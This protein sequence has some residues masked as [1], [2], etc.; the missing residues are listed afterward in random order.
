MK[1]TEPKT[2]GGRTSAL[3]AEADE[4]FYAV[5]KSWSN[6]CLLYLKTSCQLRLKSQK[7]WVENS[8]ILVHAGNFL[9]FLIKSYERDDFR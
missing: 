7:K 2:W 3:L 6:C 5:A 4:L 8:R 9:P 1:V